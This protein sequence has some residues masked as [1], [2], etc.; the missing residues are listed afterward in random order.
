[1]VLAALV[2]HVV[3][4]LVKSDA[5]A[6]VDGFQRDVAAAALGDVADNMEYREH[7]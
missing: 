6:V 4:T 7:W 5:T 2:P 3:Q 1:M